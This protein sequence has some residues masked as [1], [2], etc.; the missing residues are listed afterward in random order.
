MSIPSEPLPP[1]PARTIP[2]APPGAWYTPTELGWSLRRNAAVLFD[3]GGW[4][5]PDGHAE[6]PP[7][8]SLPHK[9]RHDRRE[10]RPAGRLPVA[11]N[12][13]STG[14]PGRAR[15]LRFYESP[16]MLAHV[17]EPALS[18]R[19]AA[20]LRSTHAAIAEPT[21]GVARRRTDPLR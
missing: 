17:T 3:D 11:T 18:G 19:P 5:L 4:L 6:S 1:A 10:N 15:P 16:R 7:P 8:T 2:T 12:S 13:A 20:R 9:R 21:F 14:A